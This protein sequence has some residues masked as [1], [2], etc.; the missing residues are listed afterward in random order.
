MSKQRTN[1]SSSRLAAV[2][3]LYEYGFGEKTI[4]QI[5]REF[6]NGD[7]GAEVIE[8]KDDFGTEEFAPV[9]PAEPTLFSG[10]LASYA[11]NA[12][13]INEM[14]KS[15]LAADWTEDR[16]EKTLKAI[17]QAGI[18]ELL[19]FPETPV[20]VILKEYVDLASCFYDGAEIR[21]TNG[22][23]SNIAKALRDS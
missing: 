13:H 1:R 17:L 21:V 2:Q 8:E 23:L 15:S 18:A 20:A 9:M 3:A 14:I 5:A 11:E 19:A 16:V 6:M 7:I 12:D 22:I 4:D 10:I